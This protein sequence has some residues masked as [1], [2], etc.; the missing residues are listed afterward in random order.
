MKQ[1]V[2]FVLGSASPARLATLRSAGFAPEVIVSGVDES[3]V[4]ADSAAALCQELAR[5]KC[6][7]VAAR[8]ET[9]GAL[10]LGCDSVLEF[11][12]GTYG[13]PADAAE[14]VARLGRMRGRSGVLHTGHH[15]IDNRD[16]RATAV[17]EVASTIV[18][19]AE[20]TDAEI[21]AYVA[22]GEP[23]QVAGSF[24]IDGLGAPFVAS[25]EGDPSTV[26]GVSMPL[27]RTLLAKLGLSVIDLWAPTA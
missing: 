19:F 7:A 1:R 24:T 22:T 8:P 25:V 15:L 2:R 14:A 27:L 17:G 10:V 26:V 21:E 13:K 11:E 6:E 5:L 18:R 3:V 23:L 12:G 9:A 16:G 4:S 20:L